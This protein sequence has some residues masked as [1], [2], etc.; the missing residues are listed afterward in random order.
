[1]NKNK[2]DR[3]LRDFEKTHTAGDIKR[4]ENEKELARSLGKEL[5]DIF[6]IMR[7]GI[8]K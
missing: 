4:E 3:V 1:M 5:S 7:K 8:T 6:K 2:L